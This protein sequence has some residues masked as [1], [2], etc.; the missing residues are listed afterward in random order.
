MNLRFSFRSDHFDLPE[1][2]EL[3][4]FI[5]AIY[6]NFTSKPY[7]TYQLIEKDV[8]PMGQLPCGLY[9]SFKND[10]IRVLEKFKN[11]EKDDD[12]RLEMTW[13]VPGMV[14]VEITNRGSL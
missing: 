12:L 6:K 7:S 14:R 4:E 3:F 13:V 8:V 2:I 1:P 5:R 11:L 9:F 10:P